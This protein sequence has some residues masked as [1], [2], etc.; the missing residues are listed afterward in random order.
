MEPQ[1][2]ATAPTG[3]ASY[4][5]HTWTPDAEQ[6]EA[7]WKVPN[8]SDDLQGRQAS[9]ADGADADEVIE[10]LSHVVLGV[11]NL[12]R[13]EK[14]YTEF[15]P[16]DLIG[17]NLTAEDRPHSV[18]QT[19]RGQLVIL[20]ESDEVVPLRPGTMGMHHSFALTPNQ[21]RR[22]V[23]R[24]REYGYDLVNLR[25]VRMAHGEYEVTIPDPDGHSVEITTSGPEVGEILLPG[26]GI[27]DCGPA[28]KYRVGDVRAFSEGRFF[29]VRLKDGFLALS[30]WC[31]HRNGLLTYQR[32]H[33]QFWCPF[34]QATYDRRGEITGGPS[35]EPLRRVPVTISEAG[36]I[37]VNAEEIIR[38]DCYEPGQ[39]VAYSA[40]QGVSHG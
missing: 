22:M 16:L 8:P 18:L 10:A 37:L 11:T 15:L 4:G 38:R 25:A 35:E 2:V 31:T 36:H 5:G 21:Y 39:A 34:H 26:V 32:A 23:A 30:Q 12:E 27:V 17:R 20:V 9:R 29:L 6:R 40:R 13:S 3:S 14:W 7:G 28:E 19:N 1:R 33:W 24:A